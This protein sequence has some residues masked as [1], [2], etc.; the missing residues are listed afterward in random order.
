MRS[1]AI[2]SYPGAAINE[3]QVATARENGGIA[4][5]SWARAGPV[6]KT[7]TSGANSLTTQR[8]LDVFSKA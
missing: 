2:R 6:S 1:V 4:V 8:E 7:R 5:V 3:I